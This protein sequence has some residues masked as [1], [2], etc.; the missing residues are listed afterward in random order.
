MDMLTLNELIKQGPCLYVGDGASEVQIIDA[1][2]ALGLRFSD[3]YRSYLQKYG[4]AAVNGHE[5]TGISQDDEADV[6][7]VTKAEREVTSNIKP[8]WYVV[9]RVDIDGVVLWQDQDGNVYQTVDY[10]HPALIADSFAQCV[11][12]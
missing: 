5:I 3:E 6:V 4:I 10:G 1:Q 11:A 8:N 9:E 12:K 7:T 2:K